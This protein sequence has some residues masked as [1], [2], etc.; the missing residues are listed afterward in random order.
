MSLIVAGMM[1]LLSRK[2]SKLISISYSRLPSGSLYF[3]CPKNM[4]GVFPRH[5]I[6]MLSNLSVTEQSWSIQDSQHCN[7]K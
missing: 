3:F 4:S 2:L 5:I 6:V 7:K 1:P